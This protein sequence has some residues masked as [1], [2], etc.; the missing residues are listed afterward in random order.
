ME[1]LKKLFVIVIVLFSFHVVV[2]SNPDSQR[3]TLSS[4]SKDAVKLIVKS[5]VDKKEGYSTPQEESA[6]LRVVETEKSQEESSYKNAITGANAEF[7]KAKK[8][9]DDLTAQFQTSSSEFEEFQKNINTIKATIE[10]YDSQI[11]RFDQDITTQQESLT[12]WLKTEKQGEAVVAVI[13]T[14]GFKDTAHEL[15]KQADLI[16]APLM[17]EHMGVYVKSFTTV[18][19][20]V[21]I[22]DFIKT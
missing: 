1:A 22:E 4:D 8:R 18:I 21:M 20:N 19:N 15:D 17:A 5:E 16:S 12:K 13:Y 3:V 11:T 7:N 6:N 9:R 2:Y 14:R 10:N